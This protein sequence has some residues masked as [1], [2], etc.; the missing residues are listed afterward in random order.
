MMRFKLTVN[1]NDLTREK[2]AAAD[3]RM[4]YLAK[5]LLGCAAV[6]ITVLL[7]LAFC[8]WNFHRAFEARSRKLMSQVPRQDQAVIKEL[9]FGRVPPP[10]RRHLY[11]A[12]IKGKTRIHSARISGS[13]TIAGKEAD[14][15]ARYSGVYAIAPG[16]LSLGVY[17]NMRLSPL[18][19]TATAEFYSGGLCD[20]DTRLLSLFPH[21]QST[22]PKKQEMSFL[23]RYISHLPAYPTAFLDWKQIKWVDNDWDSASMILYAGKTELQAKFF[24]NP[25]GSIARLEIPGPKNDGMMW[26]ERYSDYKKV[27]GIMVPTRYT[28][29]WS[30][31][32]QEK[33][34]GTFIADRIE[35]E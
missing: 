28:S 30:N 19:H 22:D 24:I 3:M 14:K 25:D 5:I 15:P 11:F 9:E 32:K 7:A 33:T 34:I 27:N 4:G 26:V 17:A 10:I 12:F 21:G 29:A 13:G 8:E 18:L 35:L 16:T 31:G 2:G 6:A 1:T 20:R 23:V